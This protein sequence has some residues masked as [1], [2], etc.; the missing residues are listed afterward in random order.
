M[1][2]SQ[3]RTLDSELQAAL[4][5]MKRHINTHFSRTATDEEGVLEVNERLNNL[6]IEAQQRY[7]ELAEVQGSHVPPW[8]HIKGHLLALDGKPLVELLYILAGSKVEVF[9][10]N[11]ELPDRTEVPVICFMN[12][13]DRAHKFQPF[14]S[15]LVNLLQVTRPIQDCNSLYDSDLDV[16][17]H[18]VRLPN[19]RDV[20]EFA[21]NKMAAEEKATGERPGIFSR[22][23]RSQISEKMA[24]F[25]SVEGSR[26]P[27]EHDRLPVLLEPTEGRR[28]DGSLKT[29]AL[30]FSMPEGCSVKVDLNERGDFVDSN[31][32]I[33]LYAIGLRYVLELP[34][35]ETL[36]PDEL[37][38]K[39]ADAVKAV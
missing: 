19:Y 35:P 21:V 3:V 28:A 36:K 39:V 17:G 20:L 2:E 10:S 27:D 25:C 24:E 5:G 18:E 7:A 13:L 38:G 4:P 6:L 16:Q 31:A 12:A 1:A 8:E 29:L 14:Q 37:R 32:Y 33:N 23:G 34:F 15:P 26:G 30:N 11:R 9:R 22:R